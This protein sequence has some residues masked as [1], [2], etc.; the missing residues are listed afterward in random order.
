V[1]A[2]ALPKG[3]TKARIQWTGRA[4]TAKND[5]SEP[6]PESEPLAIN[7]TGCAAPPSDAYESAAAATSTAQTGCETP[8]TARLTG[9]VK[10][11]D[12][13]VMAMERMV[14]DGNVNKITDEQV[15]AMAITRQ[16]SRL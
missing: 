7:H 13:S 2:L 1:S 6:E 3:R 9:P 4:L 11:D 8:A 16:D 15:V 14:A 10:W 5:E 12:T